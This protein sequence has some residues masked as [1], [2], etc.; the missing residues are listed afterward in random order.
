MEID[1]YNIKTLPRG[2]TRFAPVCKAKF[3][4][5]SL[6][7]FLQKS[8]IN[9][10]FSFTSNLANL[11]SLNLTD[12]WKGG[13]QGTWWWSFWRRLIEHLHSMEDLADT[14]W[15]HSGWRSFIN[16][17]WTVF[18]GKNCQNQYRLLI[19]LFFILIVF[20]RLRYWKRESLN[21]LSIRHCWSLKVSAYVACSIT[22]KAGFW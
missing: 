13:R 11:L 15:Q 10:I 19:I 8:K 21:S 14:G 16:E 3:T 2:G 9:F 12:C 7:S 6:N 18:S 22:S 5:T 20:I 17:I 4:K 1:F